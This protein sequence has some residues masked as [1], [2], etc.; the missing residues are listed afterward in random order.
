MRK[1]FDQAEKFLV[2]ILLFLIKIYK[3]SLSPINNL[4]RKLELLLINSQLNQ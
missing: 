3:A 2:R 4:K 1:L